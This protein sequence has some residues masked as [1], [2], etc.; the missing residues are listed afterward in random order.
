MKFNVENWTFSFTVDGKRYLLT[1]DDESCEYGCLFSIIIRDS[2]SMEDLKK[3][4]AERNMKY[5]LYEVNKI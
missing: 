1:V 3:R 2:V 4:L 5:H